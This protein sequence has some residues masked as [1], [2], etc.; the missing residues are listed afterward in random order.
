MEVFHSFPSYHMIYGWAL[1]TPPLLFSPFD[2][3]D[4][5]DDAAASA[6][7]PSAP[8]RGAVV[9]LL[10][11]PL[12]PLE[13]PLNLLPS[14]FEK[15]HQKIKKKKKIESAATCT[16]VFFLS[17]LCNIRTRDYVGPTT[18]SEKKKKKNQLTF[19]VLV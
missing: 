18:L 11:G 7:M 10:F 12:Y 6:A 2:D 3:Y 9:A 15:A 4:Y 17:Y 5:D 14:L 1:Y 8:R 16:V 19:V 13:P